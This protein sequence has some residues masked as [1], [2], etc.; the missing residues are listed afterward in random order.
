MQNQISTDA[1]RP[2]ADDVLVDIAKY[3]LDYQVDSDEAWSTARL[4]L[5][6]ALG[7]AFHSLENPECARILGPVVP[8]ALLE[9][10]ARV[11]GTRL[12][13]DPVTAA[14]NIGACIRWLDFNDTWLAAEWG[15]PSD[16][17]GAILA[18][19]DYECR[20][21]RKLGHPP[22]KMHAVLDALIKAYEIQGVIALENAFNRL[23]IDHV[24]LV[25]VASAAVS[26]AILGGNR[27]QV[28]AAVSNAWLDGGALRTYRHA[29]NTGSRKSWAAPDATSRGVW[30]ALMCLRGEMGYPSALTASVWGVQD[31]LLRGDPLRIARP[32]ASYVVENLLFK[33]AFPAEFHGQTA[34]EAAMSLHPSVTTRLDDVERIELETQEAGSRI[35][36]KTGPLAN[37]ADRDHCLQYMVA[38]ALLKGTITPSDYEEEAASDPR[39]DQLRSKMTVRENPDFT[40]D[41]FD[42]EKRAITNAMR[43]YF[44]DGSATERVEIAFPLGHRRRRD[45]AI[46]PLVEK[47]RRGLEMTLA[48]NQCD[49]LMALFLDSERLSHMPVDEFVSRLVV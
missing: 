17:L 37:A 42:P 21:R 36:D 3:V 27:E 18:C 39:I 20:L 43:I 45:E 12:E 48:P 34:C 8:G 10:G 11:P 26:T 47:C 13:L 40:R 19:A 9:G 5:M 30:L 38:I 49:E 14:F 1:T 25:R 16:N 15:H 6:D 24:I 2:P 29:P 31:A 7:C 33:V 23:G 46:P 4:A 22:L 28:I 44:R 35:I 41:Y 32:Y